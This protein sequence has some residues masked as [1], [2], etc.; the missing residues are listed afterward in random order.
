MSRGTNWLTIVASFCI[1][2]VRRYWLLKESYKVLSKNNWY[3]EFAGVLDQKYANAAGNTL[4]IYDKIDNINTAEEFSHIMNSLGGNVYANINQ[5]EQTIIDVLGTSLNLLQDSKNNTKENIKINVIAGKGKLTED[6]DGVT[7]YNYESTGVTALREI[8]RTYKHTFGY[9]AGYLHTNYEM[10]DSNSSEEDADTIQF[11][12]H[13]KY[14]SNDWILRN[15]LSGRVSFHNTDR[16]IDWKD[17]GRSKMNGT[18][19]T[20]SITSDN[21]LGKELSLGKNTSITPY[22]GLDATYITRPTFSEDGLEALEV[23]GNNAWS[24]MPKAGVELK[25][26]FSL[27]IKQE[28]KLKGAVDIAYGYEL[29]DL[30]ERESAKLVNVETDYHK[31]SKPEKEKGTLTTKAIIGAEIEDRYG[32]FFT[33]EYM[34]GAD[35]ENEYRAGITLKAVF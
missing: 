12:L 8:E 15:D 27:G 7:S 19:E 13:N 28:W 32:V 4:K 2:D 20:Y 11:G 34:T 25:G 3:N 14:K 9:S 10:E 21:K 24:V 5:R 1:S 16:N 35:S 18:Y 26:E 31:L 17:A 30:N 23:K 33:G 22:G 29:G 6:S